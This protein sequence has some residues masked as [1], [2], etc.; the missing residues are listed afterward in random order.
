MI[1]TRPHT[2]CLKFYF[3]H[4][5]WHSTSVFLILTWKQ[6][7]LVTILVKIN[8]LFTRLKQTSFQMTF[9]ICHLKG[10]IFNCLSFTEGLITWLF[11]M[12]SEAPASSKLLLLLCCPKSKIIPSNEST[13]MFRTILYNSRCIYVQLSSNWGN[14][15]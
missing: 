14:G 7:F 5:R 4:F 10:L 15:L 2:T 8:I 12:D 9:L 6:S 11:T 13:E 1:K 3:L